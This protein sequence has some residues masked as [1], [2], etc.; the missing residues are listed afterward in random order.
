MYLSWNLTDPNGQLSF[1]NFICLLPQSK[2]S[3]NRKINNTAI[4]KAKTLLNHLQNFTSMFSTLKLFNL[5]YFIYSLFHCLE[6]VQS[7]SN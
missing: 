7:K 6:K 4:N 2:E 1:Q 3:A 5:I